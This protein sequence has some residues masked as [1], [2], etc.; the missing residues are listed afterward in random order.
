MT[1]HGLAA[2][3]LEGTLG[4]NDEAAFLAHVTGC[5]AC[6]ATLID[7]LQLRDQEE[8]TRERADAIRKQRSA[9]SL[10]VVPLVADASTTAAQPVVE[11]RPVAPAPLVDVPLV[12]LPTQVPPAAPSAL[13]VPDLPRR[14]FRRWIGLATSLAAVA[15]GTWLAL[16]PPRSMPP[17]L[18]LGPIRSIE[19]RLGHPATAGYRKYDVARGTVVPATA[20]GTAGHEVIAP[21]AIA[22][23]A[24]AGDCRGVA[25]AYVL[26]RE[27]VRAHDTYERCPA[28]P[29]IDAERAGLAVLRGQP[30]E[31]LHLADRALVAHPDHLVA[32][33]NRALALRDLGLGLASAE[34]FDRVAALD[35]AW[36]QEARDRAAALRG[37]LTDLRDSFRRTIAAG[38]TMV[39]GGLLIP[40]DLARRQPGRAR[41]FFHHAVRTARTRA[42][43]DELRPLA[44]TLD[45]MVGDNLARYIDQAAA[46][47]TPARLA[48]VDEYAAMVE[49]QAAPDAAAFGAWLDRARAAGA[50]DL[51]LGAL[52]A[53]HRVGDAVDEAT[54]LAAST[55]DPW[56]EL[57][58]LTARAALA[59]KAS[60]FA[61]AAALL[62]EGDRRCATGAPAFRC[63]QLTLERAQFEN[64]RYHPA[65][66]RL[67]SVRALREAT[68]IGEWQQRLH[69]VHHAGEAE[70]F[71]D[72]FAVARAFYRE[73]ALGDARCL[74]ERRASALS[75]EMSFD[76]HRVSEARAAA[77]GLPECGRPAELQELVLEANLLHSGVPVRSRAELL[78]D[79]ASARS[80]AGNSDRRFLDYL[81]ARAELGH[82]ADA[83]ARLR[84][85]AMTALAR[86]S[87]TF[88]ARAGAAAAAAAL[89]DAGSRS[90]W[91]EVFA[92]AAEVRGIDVP[93]RC[94]VVVAA[95]EFQLVGAALGPAGEVAGIHLRDM[96]RPTEWLA[97]EI[98]RERVHGCDLVDVLAAPPWLGVGPL[99]DPAVP[100]RYVLGPARAPT[101]G[102]PRRVVIA[103]PRPPISLGLPAL[104]PWTAV[105][106]A[107]LITGLSA[108]PER[109]AA[110]ARFATIL[111]IHAH[112]DRVAS[113]DAP[114][115]A[116]SEG[117]SGWAVTAEAVRE[118]RF[119]RGPVVVLADC[120]GAV[121]A[122]YV[123]TSWGLPA[124]FLGAGAR[125]VVAALAS[126]PDAAATAFF[127]GVVA[128]VERGV[129][130][131]HAVARARAAELA[132]DR[133]SWARH[134]VV[135]E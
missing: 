30:E 112:T 15:V 129:P 120:V 67:L 77:A 85:I 105:P 13:T 40:E 100:W 26:S 87:D 25:A 49:A 86:P 134:I 94:A 93:R 54:R 41:A 38:K 69:A 42:R 68:A 107:E 95:D 56:F 37:E 23:F 36:G 133:T 61:E 5:R 3:Y 131:A 51:V 127:A 104:T 48:L 126:I 8:L 60:R 89:V 110:V 45:G 22:A 115:L 113:S 57:G 82:V 50:G 59:R 1:V 125:A 90:A 46:A 75:A 78:A 119:D 10:V 97:P 34:A 118:M 24:R 98:V 80:S 65:A 29:E 73:Y 35:P 18:A 106:G 70:R 4:P 130:V 109:L 39:T 79:L 6:Q 84:S 108:T 2:E 20:E 55:G 58:I 44:A 53:T 103:E 83:Q 33:W 124:A 123:H 62:D 52:E 27:L 135:F 111:E 43:L 122:R 91:S 116:L 31:A 17:T 14:R 76:E 92:I 88:A 16:R 71:R 28:S 96:A 19:T 21:E 9:P 63:V 128:D 32:L 99:L 47:L 81:V 114:A 11:S 117:R 64:D 74:A 101:A 102:A 132:R 121:P 66:A 72:G 7:D 12:V